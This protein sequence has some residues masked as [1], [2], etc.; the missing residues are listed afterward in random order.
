MKK[1]EIFEDVVS[2]LAKDSATC[3]DKGI[4]DAEKYRAQIREDMNDEEFA[5]LVN[6]YVATLGVPAHLMF[7]W[8]SPKRDYLAFTTRRFGDAL[9]VNEVEESA[10]LKVG[11]KIVKLDGRTIPEAAEEYGELL[12]GEIP[13]RQTWGPVIRRYH[14]MTVQYPDGTEKEMTIPRVMAQWGAEPKFEFE[15]IDDKTVLLRFGDFMDSEKIPALIEEYDVEVCSSENLIID[16]RENGGGM[17]TLFYPLIKYC[18]PEGEQPKEESSY[19]MEINFSERNVELRVALFE[20][21]RKQELPEETRDWLETAM[22]TLKE[23]KGR[24]FLD[25]PDGEEVERG[26]GGAGNPKRVYILSDCHCGSSGDA[27]VEL[28]RE[29]P[30]V[31]VVGRPTMGIL[32][33][34]NEAQISYGDFHFLYPTSRLK[35]IDHGIIMGGHGVPVDVYVPWTPEHLTHD[36]DLEKVLELIR[37]Q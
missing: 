35:A 8:D 22:K 1:T 23:N 18:F 25:D 29:S 5:V 30:K 4:G 36:V 15:R 6:R 24:G 32:D 16:V 21:Y 17:D 3:K 31:T 13:E 34:S 9:Y 37:A 19:G 26:V 2:I 28:M 12:Y 10:A 33:Y 20:E 14:T 11:D 27:F 7:Y